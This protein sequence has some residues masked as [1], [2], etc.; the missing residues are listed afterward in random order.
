MRR[1]A[2]VAAVAAL[3]AGCAIGPAANRA[4]RE[5][6]SPAEEPPGDPGGPDDDPELPPLPED[7][8]DE[9]RPGPT[10]APATGTAT[11]AETVID[12]LS[13][14]CCV[15]RVPDSEDLLLASGD[16]VLLYDADGGGPPQELGQVPGEIL[17]L[18][19]P[20]SSVSNFVPVFAYYTEDD[21]GQVS[22]FRYYPDRSWE[23]WGA[24][25]T[26]LLNDPIPVPADG[27]R[28]GGALAFGPDGDLYLGTGDAG[29][30]ELARSEESSLG[31]ILRLEPGRRSDP[32]V[33]S[34]GGY[35]DVRGIAW[36]EDR[37]W[38]VDAGAD[39]T[40]RVFSV[41]PGGEPVAV[42]EAEGETPAGLAAAGGPLWMPGAGSG[43]LWRVPLHGTELV[44]DPGPDTVLDLAEPGAV[45]GDAS[46]TGLLALADGGLVRLEV[47]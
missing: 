12:Q 22:S 29:D 33:H 4:E 10:P 40:A 2:A 42:W 8:S 39:G 13:A 25:P 19:V 15:A 11:E 9:P 47:E 38:A 18:A 6:G 3:A 27:T 43:Q 26:R 14:V 28:A 16:T 17:G 30:P 31:K 36:D 46:G 45:I 41:T 1:V 5:A 20:R 21:G 23:P 44:P 7:P 24:T 35:T 32:V 34:L 37:M